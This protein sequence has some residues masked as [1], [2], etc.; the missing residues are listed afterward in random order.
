MDSACNKNTFSLCNF[1]LIWV[2]ICNKQC[3]NIILCNTL[4][5]ERNPHSITMTNLNLINQH[6]HIRI[7]IRIEMADEHIIKVIVK[8]KV[9]TESKISLSIFVLIGILVVTYWAASAIPTWLSWQGSF[10]GIKERFHALVVQRIWF[11]KIKNV[12][13]I[14]LIFTC[15]LDFKEIPLGIVASLVVRFEN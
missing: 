2:K 9:K 10:R 1:I 4:T 15:V 3:V 13:P 5:Q 7:S 14:Y 8:L 11:L 12:E 6:F